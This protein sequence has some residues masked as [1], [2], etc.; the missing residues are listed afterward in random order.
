MEAYFYYNDVKENEYDNYKNVMLENLRTNI[1]EIY[2]LSDEDQINNYIVIDIIGS[3]ILGKP[4]LIPIND[5][6][7]PTEI[8]ISLFV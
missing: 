2:G 7:T 6:K 5:T 1:E 3:I 4:N 8:K